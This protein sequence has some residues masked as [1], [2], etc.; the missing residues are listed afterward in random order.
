MPQPK[1]HSMQTLLEYDEL[2]YFYEQATDANDKAEMH[3]L[4]K[5]IVAYENRWSLP[6]YFTQSQA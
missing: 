5:Q 4:S 1:T 3:S 2:I 6:C